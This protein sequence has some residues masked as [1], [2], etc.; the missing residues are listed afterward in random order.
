MEQ[1]SH[2]MATFEVHAPVTVSKV[3]IL[4]RDDS[5]NVHSDVEPR[6]KFT[7]YPPII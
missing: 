6:T 5:S 1:V 2:Q 4:F 7:T 3:G